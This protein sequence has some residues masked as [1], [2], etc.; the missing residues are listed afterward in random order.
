VF[1]VDG[2]RYLDA[3]S[4]SF[5][6]QMGYSR[7]DLVRAAA[8][9]AERLP[10]ARPSAFESVESE[11][12]ARELLEAVGPPY[13]R[14]ILTSSG[15]EAVEAA[16]K[17]THFRQKRI[18]IAHLKGHFHGA[19]LTALGVGDYR[20]RRAPY[21][22]VLGESAAVD[23]GDEDTLAEALKD[24]AALIAETVPAVGRGV[25]LPP[26]GRLAS[27]RRACDAAGALW[28][29]DE[30]LTGFGR[31]G[32]LFAWQR[33][34]QQPEDEGV[35]PDMIVFGKGAGA[36]YAALGGVLLSERVAEFTHAQT[37]GGHAIACAV[38]RR[39]LAAMREE[40]IEERVRAGE[41]RLR[42]A[43]EPLARHER[44]RQV[45]GLGYLW[46]IHLRQARGQD[47]PFPRELRIAE[48]AEAAC[49]DR[50]ILI[51]GGSGAED[52]ERGDHLIVAPPLNCEAHHFSQIA[53]GIRQV[54][55]E[56][57]RDTRSPGLS[58][59]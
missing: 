22:A 8:E 1:D 44:V 34:V 49:R 33:L 30:V 59:G 42:E 47:E 26:P 46:G 54:L 38:G 56:V 58:P 51:Y 14:V 25:E 17:C 48:R 9:A 50:G 41:P 10:F 19:T 55:D 35:A 16:L 12:Y 4:G 40:K 52:G 3:I 15:S 11:S 18:R 45:R 53:I 31:V 7:P 6:V 28:I 13:T 2:H 29:A 32:P 21:E 43:L 37:Y 57:I 36:G 5:C 24:S 23:P 20:S 27:F 39:V